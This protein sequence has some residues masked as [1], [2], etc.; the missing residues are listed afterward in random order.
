MT[1][2]KTILSPKEVKVT[3]KVRTSSMRACQSNDSLIKH[4]FSFQN[5]LTGWDCFWQFVSKVCLSK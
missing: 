1:P 5:E 4:D 2:P 3:K